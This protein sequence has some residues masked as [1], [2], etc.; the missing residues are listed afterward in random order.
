MF[1]LL[2]PL[3]IGAAKWIMALTAFLVLKKWIIVGI[4]LFCMFMVLKGLHIML[5]FLKIIMAN[6]ILRWGIGLMLVFGSGAI[7]GYCSHTVPA[8][9]KIKEVPVQKSKEKLRSKALIRDGKTY[10][11]ADFINKY[12]EKS[13][14]P[15][16]FKNLA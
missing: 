2:L 13:R 1:E 6:T 3:G 7:L 16:Q 4:G 8:K 12:L 10:Y 11:S 5:E 15:E 14:A 9:E